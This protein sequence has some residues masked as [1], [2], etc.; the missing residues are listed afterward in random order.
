MATGR[1]DDVVNT[2]NAVYPYD[3]ADFLHARLENHQ[4]E[5]PLDGITRG[6]YSLVYSDT[7]SDTF[8]KTETRRKL[9]DLTFSLGLVAG[10]E[11]K[12]TDVL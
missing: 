12:L 1:R 7:P 10:K 9:T 8:K 4:R 5:A 3:W 6:G 11:S 2:L